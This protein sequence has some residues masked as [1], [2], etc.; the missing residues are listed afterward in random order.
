L[1]SEGSEHPRELGMS[2]SY[3]KKGGTHGQTQER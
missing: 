3:L 2:D 1:R